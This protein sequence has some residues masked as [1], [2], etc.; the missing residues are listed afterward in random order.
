MSAIPSSAKISASPSFAQQ[1]PTA[2]RSICR[3]ATRGDL[4][5]LACGRS[6]SPRAFAA[7]CMRDRLRVSF[8][9]STRTAGVGISVRCIWKC[10]M[11]NDECRNDQLCHLAWGHL[12]VAVDRACSSLRPD[13]SLQVWKVAVGVFGIARRGLVLDDHLDGVALVLVEQIVDR[14]VRTGPRAPASPAPLL[15]HGH[16]QDHKEDEKND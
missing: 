14:A 6:R 5:V 13:R 12:T 15:R 16:D 9:D 10:Q 8:D 7:D 2:P 11:L 1:M 4:C 3:A